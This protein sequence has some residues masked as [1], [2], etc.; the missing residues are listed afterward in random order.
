VKKLNEEKKISDGDDYDKHL[1]YLQY[2]FSTFE[3]I[4]IDDKT[5]KSINDI[6]DICNT[7]IKFK[8]INTGYIENIQYQ[9]RCINSFIFEKEKKG[10]KL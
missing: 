9:I 7:I 2:T 6:K 10:K 4:P 8:E 1:S 3:S 5:K